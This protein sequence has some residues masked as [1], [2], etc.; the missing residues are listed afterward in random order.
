[1]VPTADLLTAAT[2]PAD[3][4]PEHL[5]RKEHA[6]GVPVPVPAG[7]LQWLEPT[8]DPAPEH[9][10][11]APDWIVETDAVLDHLTGFYCDFT[12]HPERAHLI[13]D[14]WAAAHHH[15]F[16]YAHLL[17]HAPLTP[18]ER[19]AVEAACKAWDDLPLA[20]FYAANAAARGKPR[21][22]VVPKAFGTVRDGERRCAE[23]VR[24]HGYVS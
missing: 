6:F 8:D 17:A 1:L 13:D 4:A 18:P 14:M 3:L 22:A 5:L 19:E 2:T 9:G 10:L 11:Q 12:A 15:T 24:R 20:L 23:A 16:R 21:P 7:G